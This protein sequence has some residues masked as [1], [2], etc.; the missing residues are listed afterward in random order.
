MISRFKD[1]KNDNID[2]SYDPKWLD[3][4]LV[5]IRKPD[6]N[7]DEFLNENKY[8]L[9]KI[10]IELGYQRATIEKLTIRLDKIEQIIIK[11]DKSINDITEVL[12][13]IDKNITN[14]NDVL[15]RNNLK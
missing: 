12:K 7:E 8:S 9:E 3:E 4:F 15:K 10:A 2:E 6:F 5:E 11:H 14:I 1:F 13:K